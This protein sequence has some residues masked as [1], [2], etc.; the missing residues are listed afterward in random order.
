MII[1]KLT[2]KQKK[3]VQQYF[4]SY[5][6]SQSGKFIDPANNKQNKAN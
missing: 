5:T 3:T 4:V 2:N 6:N 1:F